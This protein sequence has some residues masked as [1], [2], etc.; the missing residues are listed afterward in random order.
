LEV[1]AQQLEPPPDLADE[2]YRSPLDLHMAALAAVCACRDGE[3]VPGHDDLSGYLLNHERRCWGDD[4]SA[5]IEQTVFV[6]TLFGPAG[7]RTAA[8][9]LLRRA[10]L[11]DGDAMAEKI[12]T[13]HGNPYP[14][15]SSA[16]DRNIEILPPLRPDRLGE[17]FVAQCLAEQHS[18]T[19]L[20]A[21]LVNGT[22]LGAVTIRRSLTVL[23]AAATRNND[24]RDALLTAMRDAPILAGRAPTAIQCVIDHADPTLAATV[25]D[26]L[27]KFST[28]FLRPAADL[29]Q[30]LADDPQAGSDRT[31][32]HYLDELGIRLA[33]LRRSQEALAV[34][35]EAV[36]LIPSP[37]AERPRRPPARSRHSPAEPG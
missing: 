21:L 16:T 8:R 18:R 17:D 2:A 7:D 31:R 10:V 28:E 20:H 35:E 22:T 11:A 33:E 13:R 1:A 4:D 30:R 6:A 3:L 15:W 25:Y 37:G 36:T 29:A 12:L 23:A 5:I 34:A 9:D 27:P 24:A 14:P 26:A 19:R 32:A